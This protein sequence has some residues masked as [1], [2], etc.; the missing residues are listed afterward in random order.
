MDRD[1][2]DQLIRLAVDPVPMIMGI[3]KVEGLFAYYYTGM[4]ANP[5]SVKLVDQHL[6]GLLPASLIPNRDTSETFGLPNK[7]VSPEKLKIAEQAVRDAYVN[8]G[9]FNTN[10]TEKLIEV[11]ALYFIH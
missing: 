2:E 5:A 6:V 11:S 8:G 7:P 1:P 10:N 3:N 9:S 4:A